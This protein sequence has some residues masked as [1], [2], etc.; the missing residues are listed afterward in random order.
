MTPAI[1]TL[2]LVEAVSFVVA[3]LVHAGVLIDGYEHREART[4]EGIIAIVIIA[5]LV[6]TWIR[7]AWTRA[8]A[9][10][11]QGF[12]LFGTLVGVFVIIIGVGPRTV[13]DVVYHVAIVAVLIYGLVVAGRSASMRSGTTTSPQ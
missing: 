8:A 6:L 10:A 2:L 1:R 3:S 13:P 5:G 4:A 11:A 9:L 7:P 12:A